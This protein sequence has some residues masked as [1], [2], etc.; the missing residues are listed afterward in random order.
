[1]NLQYL[2]NNFLFPLFLGLNMGYFVTSKIIKKDLAQQMCKEAIIN[3]IK[4]I[5][6]ELKEEENN[7]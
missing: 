2:F 1:M 6:N 4:E 3:A 7:E 5:L